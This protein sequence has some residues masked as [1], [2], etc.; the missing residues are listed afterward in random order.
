MLKLN[1]DGLKRKLS[2][3]QAPGAGTDRNEA[4]AIGPRWKTIAIGILATSTAAIVGMMAWDAFLTGV[5][6]SPTPPPPPTAAAR[7]PSAPSS[8]APVAPAQ[9]TPPVAAPSPGSASGSSQAGLEPTVPSVPSTPSVPPVPPPPPA[10][11]AP[12]GQAGALATGAPKPALDQAAQKAGTQGARA[13][14]SR[15][16]LD[17]RE[18]LK[19]EGNLAVHQCAENFR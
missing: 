5:P 12:A 7:P 15:S 14:T 4:A 13:L 6:S 2:P 9:M 16:R 10:A 18:C 17:A 3:K 1:L 8:P 11:E 19:L